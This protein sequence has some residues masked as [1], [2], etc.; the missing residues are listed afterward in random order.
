MPEEEETPRNPIMMFFLDEYSSLGVYHSLGEEADE[1]VA[2]IYDH[3]GQMLTEL[4]RKNK[5]GI[6]YAEKTEK[7]TKQNDFN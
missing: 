6:I 2:K 4:M 7:P 1:A 5:A 3:V